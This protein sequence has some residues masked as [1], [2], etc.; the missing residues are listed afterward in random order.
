MPNITFPDGTCRSYEEP[1]TVSAVAA[2]IGPGLAKAA[3][4]GEINGQLVDLSYRVEKDYT[5][6][7]IT[8]RDPEGLDI[9]RHSAA[10]LM[11]QAVKSLYP[12]ARL[13]LAQS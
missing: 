9:L 11:A 1:V 5:L 4:A 2:S 7:I 13:P 6:R 12:K 3:L 8:D 10:H